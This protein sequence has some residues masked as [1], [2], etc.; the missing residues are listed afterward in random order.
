VQ[1]LVTSSN[2]SNIAVA[3]VERE[4]ER[5]RFYDQL[6][7]ELDVVQVFAP[8]ASIVDTPFV[9]DQVLGPMLGLWQIDR[10]GPTIKIYQ[11]EKTEQAT[12]LEQLP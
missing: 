10:P 7:V 2:I 5:Q 6:E 9:F 11:L 12:A 4:K 8:H 1:Y 3:D